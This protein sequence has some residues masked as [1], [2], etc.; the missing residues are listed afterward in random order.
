MSFDLNLEIKAIAK[1][2][3]RLK[4]SRARTAMRAAMTFGLTPLVRAAKTNARRHSRGLSKSIARKI[5]AYPQNN[6]VVAVVGAN[7]KY[8]DTDGKSPAFKGH[9][10]EFG[11]KPHSTLGS[12]EQANP[13]AKNHPG[14]PASPWLEPAY[15]STESAVQRRI[16]DKLGERVILEM[17]RMMK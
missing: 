2:L 11:T 12:R 8:T 7:R 9:F 17:R 16:A 1:S 14:T 13:D 10:F 3:D 4:P 15:K 5:T 6:T